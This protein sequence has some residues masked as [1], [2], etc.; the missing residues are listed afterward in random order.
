MDEGLSKGAATPL[1]ATVFAKAVFQAATVLAA[2]A[3][4][5]GS[6]AQRLPKGIDPAK[7]AWYGEFYDLEAYERCVQKTNDPRNKQCDYLR[8]IREEEPEY[9]P[10]P[11]VPKPKLPEAPN[12]PVYRK[13]MSSKQYFEALCKA[14]AGEFIY[15]TIEHVEGI[16]QIRP[17]KMASWEAIMDRYVLEDPYGYTNGEATTPQTIYAYAGRRYRFFEVPSVEGKGPDLRY[18][19]TFNNRRRFESEEPIE[20][21]KSQYGFYWRGIK[22]PMDRELGIAGGELIVVRLAT[23]EVLG[24]RRGFARSGFVRNSRSGIQWETA[25]VCPKLRTQPN[26]WD[27]WPEF[28]FAFVSKVLVPAVRN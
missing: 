20:T 9:W 8:L 4:C 21:L 3:M 11:N 15:K 17:R 1:T 5:S 23:N 28:N 2:L 27:K 26:S 25:E 12:P 13:G 24:I 6:L 16:Y 14:E 18:E 19:G 10:Y 22:R 7:R